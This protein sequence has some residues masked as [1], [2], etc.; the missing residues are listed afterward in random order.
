M[1]SDPAEYQR[2]LFAYNEWL[3]RQSIQQASAP[4]LQ[5]QAQIAR[6]ASRSDP[7]YSDVWSEYAPEI[8][9]LMASLPVEQRANPQMWNQAAEMVAGRHRKELARK[10]AERLAA[11]PSDT[12]TI[13]TDG[14]GD[15]TGRAAPSD[16]IDRLFSEHP[17]IAERYRANG[18]DAAKLRSHLATM[19]RDPAQFVES[20]L[21][22]EVIHG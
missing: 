2:Q 10:L 15:S 7:E 1:Y 4:F 18:V 5:S 19:G 13:S 12:G 3:T 8:D 11:S 9:A 17:E 21:K 6:N 22:R 16:P 14:V 20:L